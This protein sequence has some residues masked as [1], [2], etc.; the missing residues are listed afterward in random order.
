MFCEEET[1]E[2][3]LGKSILVGSGIIHSE[4]EGS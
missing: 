2:T 4:L 3:K 1:I